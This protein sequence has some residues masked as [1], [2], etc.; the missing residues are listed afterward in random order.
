MTRRITLGVA[1]ALLACVAAA[2]AFAAVIA[3]GDEVPDVTLSMASGTDAKLSTHAGKT[4]VLYFYGTWT[5]K[6]GAESARIDTLRKAR[7]K[8]DLVV[9]GVARDA[10][11][12][13]AKKFG[14]EQKLG[15][16]QAADPK[17]ELYQ[18]FAEKGLP[19]VVIM[20]GKRKLKY[21]AG[22]VDDEAIETALAALL[23]KND[24]ERAKEAQDAKKDDAA[25]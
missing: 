22:G 11:P 12:E 8:Q 3:V 19:Y 10:K 21:S 25:K 23:G 14:E 2:A 20:D 16:A 6:A 9:I 24:A 17:A 15:F 7:A 18:R 4:V 13:D 5:K 1:S